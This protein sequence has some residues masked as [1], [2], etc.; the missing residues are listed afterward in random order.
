MFRR[1]PILSVVTFLYLGVVA[2]L[3]LTPVADRGDTSWLWRVYRQLQNN[4][5]TSW[6]SFNDLEFLANVLMFVPI[7]IFLVL[8][9]GRRWW[10]LAIILGVLS[11]CWIELAQYLWLPERVADPRDVLANGIGTVIG[12]IL[13]EMITWPAAKRNREAHRASAVP[14]AAHSRAAGR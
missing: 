5:L 1:H 2:L 9:F 10:T 8:L 13:A 4:E 11:S 3:T 7:G 6:V 12:V 14:L